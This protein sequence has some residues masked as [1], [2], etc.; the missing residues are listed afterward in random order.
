MKNTPAL[1]APVLMLTALGFVPGTYEFVVVGILPEVAAGLNVS[2][3]A[4]GKLVPALAEPMLWGRPL[5]PP[6][7][8]TFHASAC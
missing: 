8:G 5:S 3:A 7:P 1:N 4:V 6:P 2:L